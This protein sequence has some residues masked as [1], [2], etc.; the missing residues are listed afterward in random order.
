MAERR[1]WPILSAM[2]RVVAGRR[3]VAAAAAALAIGAALAG[4]S[5]DDPGCRDRADR[6]LGSP[7]SGEDGVPGGRNQVDV[8]FA[9]MMLVHHR[10]AV[11]IAALA[12]EQT[13]HSGVLA[14]AA[15][16]LATHQPEVTE[17]E[18]LLER[19]GED[20]PDDIDISSMDHTE[21]DHEGIGIG[22]MAGMASDEKLTLLAAAEG[23]T[24]DRPFLRL[25]RLHLGGG[26]AMAQA[27]QISGGDA[28]GRVVA[29][30]MELDQ[31][32]I[33]ATIEHTLRCG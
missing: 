7:V 11:E 4:C 25:V 29:Q 32:E 15:D 27:E 16:V 18:T 31:A 23:D 20:V 14:V 30:R 12:A 3:A 5:G 1:R 26:V 19:W 13:E 33:M 24:F 8:D 6:A 21:M 10:Q 2:G 17:L 9:Q 22:F 28:E